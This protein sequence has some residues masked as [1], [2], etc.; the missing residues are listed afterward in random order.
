MSELAAFFDSVAEGYD[1]AFE[2]PGPEGHALRSRQEAVL[3][4][5]GEGGGEALDAGMGPGR[6][7]AEL[8]ARGWTASGVD[9][10]PAMVDAARRRVPAAARRLGVG[11]IEEL[12]FEAE[13][14][15]LV[16]ATGVIE[17]VYEPRAVGELARV[18]RPAGR[19]VVSL[20]NSRAPYGVWRRR[21]VYP[22]AAAVKGAIHRGPPSRPEHRDPVAPGRFAAILES[23]GLRVRAAQ[24]VNS[25]LLL[26]PIDQLAPR[27]ATGLAAR[28]ECSGG[29]LGRGLATQVVLLAQRDG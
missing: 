24:R 2:D 16:V 1:R 15:D 9:V 5:A 21:V 8:E 10:S 22:A 17:Y 13:R 4:L 6:I 19:L 20:P 26:T 28:L 12:P 27:A 14:F 23:A 11:S 7:V 29:R 18:L 3:R 25:Q